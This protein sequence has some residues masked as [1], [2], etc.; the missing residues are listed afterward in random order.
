MAHAGIRI[1]IDW[2]KQDPLA[3]GKVASVVCLF[4]N[5]LIDYCSLP[6][7]QAKSRNPQLRCYEQNWATLEIMRTILKNKRNYR[8]KIGRSTSNCQATEE[9]AGADGAHGNQEPVADKASGDKQGLGSD[10]DD[11][12]FSSS[13]DDD[14]EE[15]SSSLGKRQKVT[16]GG[17]GGKKART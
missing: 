13:E 9:P 11:N 8:K 5:M 16:Q 6:I 17:T 3:L 10:N 2:R 7:T 14:D 1:D 4:S 12:K 15:G